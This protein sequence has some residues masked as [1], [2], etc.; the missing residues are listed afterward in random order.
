MDDFTRVYLAGTLTAD[1]QSRAGAEGDVAVFKLKVEDGEEKRLEWV[2]AEGVVARFVAEGGFK[3]GDQVLVH[4]VL[5]T[6][7]TKDRTGRERREF[8]TLAQR[9]AHDESAAWRTA[10]GA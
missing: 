4:G 8:F 10:H 2:R 1:P 7:A 6:R 3:A 5:G 9:L